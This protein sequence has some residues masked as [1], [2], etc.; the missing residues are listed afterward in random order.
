MLPIRIERTK[1]GFK[2]PPRH[3]HEA[4][5]SFKYIIG[6]YDR[7]GTDGCLLIHNERAIDRFSVIR[8]L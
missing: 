5:G 7:D 1:N 8:V 4:W 6:P 2:D 3:V